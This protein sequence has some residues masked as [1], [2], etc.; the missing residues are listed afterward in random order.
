MITIGPY[1]YQ[2]LIRSFLAQDR[3]SA[4]T[5]S[6][7][8][9]YRLS[10]RGSILY[11]YRSVLAVISDQHPK[12]LFIESTLQG[13]SN[14]TNKH[15]NKLRDI[16]FSLGWQVFEINLDYTPQENLI[17][18]WEQVESLIRKHNRSRKYKY[19]IKCSIQSLIR[20][21]QAFAKLHNF[22]DSIPDNIMRQLFVYKLLN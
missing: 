10:F 14:T 2:N 1:D 4:G 8:T 7:R 5:A 3:P 18:Y 21:A 22:N 6:S 20:I 16:A 13:Y 12:V 19:Y 17:S 9:G 11:S 15:I